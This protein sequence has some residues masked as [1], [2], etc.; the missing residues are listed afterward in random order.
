VAVRTDVEVA[1]R[2]RFRGEIVGAGEQE[3]TIAVGEEQVGI[4]YDAIVR[5][6]V[7]EEGR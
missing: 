5:G 6:N 1:G 2:K 3:A 4:P 7:I